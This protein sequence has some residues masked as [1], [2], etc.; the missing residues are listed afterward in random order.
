MAEEITGY[1][2][3]RNWFDWC[4]ENPDL[5]TPTHTALY[6]FSIEHW[7][8]LGRKEKFGLPTQMCMD[9]IGVSNWRTFS[10]AFNNLVDWGF[11][12]LITKSKN[13]YSATVIAIARN[14]KA[15]T[16]ALT[17]ATQKHLQKQDK[18]IAVIDKPNNQVTLEPINSEIEISQPKFNFKKSLLDL[19]ISDKIVSDWLIVRKDKKASNTETAFNAIKSQIE[20]SGKTANECI[21]IASENSWSGF[22]AKW[23]ENLN[24]SNGQNFKATTNGKLAGTYQAAEELAA[25][26][27]EKSKRFEERMQNSG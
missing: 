8:R 26:V 11:F 27:R 19:D 3:S 20:M 23:L 9:A 2:L 18:S 14:T 15:N 7:N 6:F 1:E 5:I 17:K 12:K 10:K 16:K 13:Q 21:R 24:N 4:F 22:K 25:E